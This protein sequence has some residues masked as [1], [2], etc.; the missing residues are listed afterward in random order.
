MSVQLKEIKESK[1]FNRIVSKYNLDSKKVLDLGCGT[2]QHL[3][4]FGPDSLGVTITTSEIEDG[5][6]NKLNIVGGNVEFI[7]NMGLDSDF[8]IIWANNLIE[9]LLSPHSFLIKLKTISNKDTLL[10]LGVPVIP[11]IHSLLKLK[12][13]KGSLAIN[14]VNFFNKK[15]LE[16]TVE[17]AGWRII[18]S[19]SFVFANNFLDKIFGLISPHIY[20]VASNDTGF[21]YSIKKIKECENDKR[22]QDL[23]DIVEK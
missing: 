18:D 14:H 6:N 10:I 19:K 9:H 13:F 2:G 7:D 16:K 4:K 21:K 15:T 12:K 11:K 5:R 17:R 20:I 22:Y 8:Q 23:L 1:T 3:L